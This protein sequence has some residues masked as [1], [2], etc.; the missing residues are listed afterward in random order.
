M[1]KKKDEMIFT[2]ETTDGFRFEPPVKDTKDV[3]A[4][5]TKDIFKG[6]KYPI[7]KG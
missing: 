6:F 4:L 7:T 3:V 5:E 1:K 2:I